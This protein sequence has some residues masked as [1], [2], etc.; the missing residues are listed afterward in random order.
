MLA[1]KRKLFFLFCLLLLHQFP[2]H[3]N[4]FFFVVLHEAYQVCLLHN[5]EWLVDPLPTLFGIAL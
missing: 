1:E 4:T 3:R 2:R 5:A